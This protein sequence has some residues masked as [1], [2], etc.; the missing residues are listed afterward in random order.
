MGILVAEPGSTVSLVGGPGVLAVQR[1]HSAVGKEERVLIWRGTGV[2]SMGD[3][4]FIYIWSAN[5]D[6]VG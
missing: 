4:I 2:Y 5:K 1:S 3:A 6:G